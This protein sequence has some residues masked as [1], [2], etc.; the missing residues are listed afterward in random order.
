MLLPVSKAVVLLL[1]IV[2]YSC[3][4]ILWGLCVRSLLSYTVLC[5]L[6]V[7]QSS[8]GEERA[9]CFILDIYLLDVLWLLVFCG[10]ALIVLLVLC[11][12]TSRMPWVGL[13]YVIVVF[14]WSYSLTFWHPFPP[15]GS[16]L[17]YFGYSMRF[18]TI[19][20]VRPAKSQTSL[21]IRAVWSKPLLVAWI[22]YE[23]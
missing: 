19:W 14:P 2:V 5:F 9:G 7:L 10:F 23:C 3:F 17:P 21:R 11:G 4:H 22:F 13:Q 15:T 16:A 18:P 20:Y 8:R 1:L 12:S 6:L